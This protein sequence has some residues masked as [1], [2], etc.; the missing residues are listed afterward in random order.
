MMTDLLRVAESMGKGTELYS[1][2]QRKYAGYVRSGRLDELGGLQEITGIE[3]SDDALT[4]LV[5][6]LL[7]EPG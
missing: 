1:A 4:D 3:P 5:K 7:A 2:V 6:S